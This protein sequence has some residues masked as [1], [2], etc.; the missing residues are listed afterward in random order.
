[1]RSV[2]DRNVVMRGMNLF[3]LGV[4]MRHKEAVMLNPDQEFTLRSAPSE[5][6][7]DDRHITL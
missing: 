2:V 3:E 1:M 5:C 4:R 7:V 6:L